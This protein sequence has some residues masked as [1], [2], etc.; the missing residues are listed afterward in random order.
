MEPQFLGNSLKLGWSVTSWG[1][2]FMSLLSVVITLGL[3]ISVS[4]P[5]V[6]LVLFKY[7]KISIED[8]VGLFVMGGFVFEVLYEQ[9]TWKYE[10]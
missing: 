4:D 5:F 6:P 7:A 8:V 10:A 2:S 1:P 9:Q 3:V